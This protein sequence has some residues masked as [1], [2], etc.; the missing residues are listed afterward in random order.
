M[1]KNRSFFVEDFGVKSD[2]RPQRSGV[3]QGCTLSPL[4]FIKLMS[5][6]MEDAVSTLSDTAADAYRQKRLADIAFADDIILL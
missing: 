4:L 6:V 2:E 1:T 5:A 3:S